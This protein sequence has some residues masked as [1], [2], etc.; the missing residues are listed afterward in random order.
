MKAYFLALPLL[1][2]SAA[3]WSMSCDNPRS[4]YDTTYCAALEMVQ[5]DRDLNQQYKNTMSVLSPAQK[6]IVKNAQISWLKV[7]DHECAEGST[8]LLGCANEKMAARIA[9]LKS[10]ERECRNAG[11]DNANL[12]RIE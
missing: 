4:P 5:G 7:R 11:C 6:Q 10:I 8:L 1:L 3:A 12:S 2:S 9:L